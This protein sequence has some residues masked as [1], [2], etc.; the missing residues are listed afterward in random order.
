MLQAMAPMPFPHTLLG[1]WPVQVIMSHAVDLATIRSAHQVCRRWHQACCSVPMDLKL[2]CSTCPTKH[3][4][5]N[6]LSCL[7]TSPWRI[8]SLTLGCPTDQSMVMELSPSIRKLSARTD[9]VEIRMT[10]P[11][12]HATRVFWWAQNVARLQHVSRL[13]I[14][15]WVLDPKQITGSSLTLLQLT[16]KLHCCSHQS[17]NSCIL[18][19]NVGVRKLAVGRS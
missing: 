16:T 3:E 4:W 13:V 6:A 15:N 18:N 2:N 8:R 7:S 14:D 10:D 17:S 12:Y 9:L 11:V 5:C 19:N 1:H